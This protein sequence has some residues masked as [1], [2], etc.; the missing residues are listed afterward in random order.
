M[1]VEYQHEVTNV[2]RKYL[3]V[4]LKLKGVFDWWKDDKANGDYLPA[5]TDVL[6]VKEIMILVAGSGAGTLLAAFDHCTGSGGSSSK[7]TIDWD[8][9]D[10][11]ADVVIPANSFKIAKGDSRYEVWKKLLMYF[12]GVSRIGTDGHIHILRAPAI[13]KYT[14]DDDNFDY[15]YSSDY[16]GQTFTPSY[17][18]T[19]R[20]VRLLLY[21][22]AGGSPGTVTVS[23]RATAGGVPTGADLAVGTTDGNTLPTGSPY[24]WREITFS[25]PLALTAATMYAICVTS[26]GLQNANRL[27]W[28]IDATAPAYAGGTGL[29]YADPNWSTTA[30]DNLFREVTTDSYEYALAAG[31]HP[32]FD[33][34]Y[35][36]RLVIPNK[37]VVSSLSTD[38]TQYTGSAT[39]AI[40][41][42]KMPVT[43]YYQFHLASDAQAAL[44]AA[45]IQKRFTLEAESG[46]G[47]VPPNVA[48]EMY[49]YV[50]IVDLFDG[51]T[52]YGNVGYIREVIELRD[53]ADDPEHP[54]KMYLSFGK[55][56]VGGNLGLDVG[57]TEA[58]ISANLQNQIAEIWTALGAVLSRNDQGIFI[59]A[60]QIMSGEHHFEKKGTW[61]NNSPAAGRV[62]WAGVSLIYKG[63]VY[64]ITDS[65]T[66]LATDKY[67]WWDYSLSTTT[68][69]VSATRPTLTADDCLIAINTAGVAY[70]QILETLIHGN[71]IQT[72]TVIADTLVA[73]LVLSTVIVAG[74]TTG[75]RVELSSAGLVCV[76]QYIDLTDGTLHGYVWL[77]PATDQLAITGPA[78]GI[79]LSTGGDVESVAN[80]VPDVTLSYDL[81]STSLIWDYLYCRYIGATGTKVTTAYITTL[82]VTNIGASDD[83]AGVAY[84]TNI[85]VGTNIDVSGIYKC[86]GTSGYSGLITAP[87][88]SITVLGGII[89]GWT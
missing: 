51:Q 33:K 11:L 62:A 8:D 80:I 66:P 42:A 36:R 73:T 32:F 65:N 35:Q 58:E 31:S 67:I 55:P 1:W 74:T 46:S 84:I 48:Q 40:S 39:D 38:E 30:C 29:S 89:T 26:P 72:G 4:Q 88:T 61:S 41:Y 15:V 2:R 7:Y 77:N 82:K 64:A 34:G 47:N 87:I 19:I 75:S 28:R 3:A 45:A 17:P 25:S 22:L 13:E 69:Q 23:I 52:R 83:Y 44:I 70:P 5:E 71:V 60:R 12:D 79:L 50:A 81:G 68:F 78:L 54:C 37:V 53:Y 76:G 59:N 85:Y 43:W 18:H 57:S 86:S 21:R 63:V 10:L 9:Q 27:N 16:I 24:E 20:G 14:T 56:I 49:D 6:K